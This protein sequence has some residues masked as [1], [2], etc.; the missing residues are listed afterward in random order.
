LS[1][2]ASDGLPNF[3][4]LLKIFGNSATFREYKSE[5]FFKN[6]IEGSLMMG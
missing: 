1:S 6:T 5:A 3:T 4:E 2:R